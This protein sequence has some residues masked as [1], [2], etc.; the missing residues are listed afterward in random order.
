MA[1][2]TTPNTE[3]TTATDAK[4]VSRAT[5]I[6]RA[7]VDGYP[8]KLF[9]YKQAASKYW[10]VRLYVGGKVI[11]KTT[12]HT[13]KRKAIAFAKEF[14][15]TAMYNQ[16]HG[17]VSGSRA[18]FEM[19]AQ[20]VLREEKAKLKR[21][22]LTQITYDNTEYRF[23]KFILPFFREKDVTDIDYD[24]MSEYLSHLSSQNLSSSTISAYVRLANKVL[25]YAQKK[26]LIQ[27]IP[28]A[29]KVTVKD[30]PRGWFT[31]REYKRLYSA[32]QRYKGKRIQVRKYKD[33]KG[34]TQT[35]YIDEARKRGR[36]GEL[37]RNVD[38]TVDMREL[39]VF[40]VN[41]YIR[42]TDIKFMKHE[43]IDVVEDEHRY[44][45]LRIPP[46]KNHSDPIVTMKTAVDVYLR[47][48]AHHALSDLAKDSDY[49][50]LPKYGKEQR[51][52]A[53]KQLQ[54]QFEIL[55]WDTG[56]E[57]GADGEARSLYSLR[58]TCIMYRLLYGD[59]M[60]TLVLARN[61]RTSVEMIDR[62]YA[63]PLSGEM[64][65]EMLQS[66]RRKRNNTEKQ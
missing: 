50:F 20:A 45:R 35:Q 44:L 66:R 48:K 13:D 38:M 58:H 19:C 29:P 11:R 54:R 49:V 64:N 61:A 10:W 14:Y 56:L 41:S 31:V 1:K 4:A 15:D 63:K 8:N 36:L 5:A 37:M 3:N 32:A 55:L 33:E 62:F 9:I 59:G 23:N 42:P 16:R 52:Y 53:L 6:E 18:N 65:I 34:E 26:R 43:H 47:L 17:V 7:Q 22:E 21:G 40:M 57:K 12:K 60:N 2:K 25:S 27:A 46:T 28:Q 24:T 39:I 51:D 30:K